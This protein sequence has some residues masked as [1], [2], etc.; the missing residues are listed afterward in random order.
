M[1]TL[2]VAYPNSKYGVL[3]F[4]CSINDVAKYFSAWEIWSTEFVVGISILEGRKFSMYD[5]R[6]SIF[7]VTYVVWHI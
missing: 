7:S 1:K 4:G 3:G 6:F 2:S 5:I